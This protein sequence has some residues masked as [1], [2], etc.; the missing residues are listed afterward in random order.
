MRFILK[1]IGIL[2]F[3]V[4]VSIIFYALWSSY[5]LFTG[6]RPAPEIF[7]MPQ[8]QNIKTDSREID[9]KSISAE[10][11]AKELAKGFAAVIPEEYPAIMFN[12]ISWSVLAL[13]MIFGGSQLAK[14]GI[15]LLSGV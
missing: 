6:R 5:E 8:R 2:L 3:F 13:I 14:L 10:I 4:G 11:V 1:I 9:L 15:G 7:N 12:M